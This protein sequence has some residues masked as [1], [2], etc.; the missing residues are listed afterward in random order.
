MMSFFYRKTG[1][2]ATGSTRFELKRYINEPLNN[3]DF[4]L[5]SNP[6]SDNIILFG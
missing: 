1:K 2:R 4:S 6:V 5:I 3:Q